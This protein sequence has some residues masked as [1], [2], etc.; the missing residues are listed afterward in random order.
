MDGLVWKKSST[1]E[2]GACVEAALPPPG[3]ECE[4]VACAEVAFRDNT[5]FMRNS[6]NPGVELQFTPA[7]WK[8][9][10]EGVLQGEFDL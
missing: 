1:C 8:A 10:R 9:F 2:G 4:S 6:Q 5:Y 3:P 7:E